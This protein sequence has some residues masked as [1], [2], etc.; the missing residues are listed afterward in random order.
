M[1]INCWSFVCTCY[2]YINCNEKCNNKKCVLVREV[3]V[4]INYILEI[5]NRIILYQA[6]FSN[7]NKM[8]QCTY[9]ILF[10]Y[11]YNIIYKYVFKIYIY[12]QYFILLPTRLYKKN[13]QTCFQL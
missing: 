12:H 11:F 5:F 13:I 2:R 6:A 10:T 9:S 8:S 1:P 3:N 7:E 4:S